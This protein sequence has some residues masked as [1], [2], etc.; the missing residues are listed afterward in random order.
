MKKILFLIWFHIL[1]F[2]YLLLLD[3]FFHCWKDTLSVHK[4]FA[5]ISFLLKNKMFFVVFFPLKMFCV[6]LSE[7]SLRRKCLIKDIH[8]ISSRIIFKKINQ[9]S[10]NFFLLGLNRKIHSYSLP[11]RKK[12]YWN[13]FFSLLLFHVHN[14][15][16]TDCPLIFNL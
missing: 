12:F 6:E 4:F 15:F 2:F 8:L 11:H 5:K 3:I 10:K 9:E 7:K 16:F 1:I 14:K 13:I